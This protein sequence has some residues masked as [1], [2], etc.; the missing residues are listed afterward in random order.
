MLALMSPRVQLGLAGRAAIAAM[1]VVLQH[2]PMARWTFAR[3]DTEPLPGQILQ[4]PLPEGPR[5]PLAMIQQPQNVSCMR[6][7][8]VAAMAR[9]RVQPLLILSGLV[10]AVLCRLQKSLATVSAVPSPS[11]PVRRRWFFNAAASAGVAENLPAYAQGIDLGFLDPKAPKDVAVAPG[12]AEVTS[13]GLKSKLL[14]RP[15]CALSKSIPLTNPN[16][17]RPQPWDKVLIDYTGW[18]P[19]GKMID[20][21][22]NEK[23]LVRVNSVMPG[24]T[25]GLQM[26][27]PG[28]SRRFWIPPELAFGK[29]ESATS[30]PTGP[31]VFD[32]ELYSIERQPKPPAELTAAPQD[33]VSTPSGLAYKK[34][35]PGTGSR[36]PG[37]DSN[38]TA[39]YNGWSSNGDLV[40]STS[41]GAQDTFFIKEVPVEGLKEALQ[42]LVEGETRRFWI[43]GKLAFGER[44][45]ES[46]GLPPGVLVF[47][48]TPRQPASLSLPVAKREVI[49]TQS[50]EVAQKVLWERPAKPAGW[51]A[52]WEVLP[53][54]PPPPL[55]QDGV[56]IWVPE[57][58]EIPVGA[59]VPHDAFLPHADLEDED[60]DLDDMEAQGSAQFGLDEPEHKLDQT[61]N[62][63]FANPSTFQAWQ[64]FA[65]EATDHDAPS[66]AWR[67][68]DSHMDVPEDLPVAFNLQ[69]GDVQRLPDPQ[70]SAGAM[71]QSSQPAR[72]ADELGMLLF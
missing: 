63:G 42:L 3:E 49:Q 66:T 11:W 61:T 9:R 53:P 23:R 2:P 41:F 37:L 52:I 50:P 12:D 60:M 14:L 22:R 15:T 43:P 57:G 8:A 65:T 33:A 1:A 32:V 6:V 26:M 48:V 38:V 68:F 46:R 67:P 24:W 36:S 25:E 55:D 7:L 34:L 19:A 70:I 45:E 21:S 27:A 10:I 72:H 29:N 39:L 13:S 20:S 18:T 35:K 62:A 40:L 31:L 54:P 56:W 28:E 17:E 44:A 71:V 51:S 69:S 30:K 47:D 59:I 5:V 4:P 16:C 64:P 58:E